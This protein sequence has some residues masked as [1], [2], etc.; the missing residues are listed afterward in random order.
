M[1]S[2]DE[3]LMVFRQREFASPAKTTGDIL[4]CVGLVSPVWAHMCV[5]ATLSPLSRFFCAVASKPTPTAESP[6]NRKFPSA[7]SVLVF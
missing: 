1:S 4:Q 3:L 7:I 2:P 5:K 6:A